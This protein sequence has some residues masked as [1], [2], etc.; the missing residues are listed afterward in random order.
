MNAGK[1][2]GPNT[3]T[4]HV[5]VGPTYV[6]VA[7]LKLT[8]TSRADVQLN[9]GNVN[10]GTVS[11]GSKPTQAI[12]VEYTGKQKDWK[13]VGVVP[14]TGPL[15][16]SVKEA[17]RGFLSTPM[18]LINGTAKYLVSVTLRAD[19]PPGSLTEVI[20]LKTNDPAAPLVSINVS[21]VVEAPLSLSADTVR[22]DRVK[23]GESV[24]QKLIV[25]A[26]TG[27]FRIQPIMDNG[28][29]LSVETF[30]APAP[31][32]I[33]TVRFTPKKPGHVKK[34]MK[35]HTDLGGGATTTIRV[36]GEGIE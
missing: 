16:V 15:D 36:E 9:P 17:P 27:P 26:A 23:V 28:D 30:P 8:A 22:F 4:L 14:P 34:E 11:V 20:Q 13:I 21:G 19:A 12:T 2:H 33:I 3:Q 6:S 29:G 10:F 5:T 25:R 32:Q 7:V 1:F 24:T 18:A 31:V 35:L